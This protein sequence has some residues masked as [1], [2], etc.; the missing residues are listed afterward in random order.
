MSAQGLFAALRAASAG[1]PASAFLRFSFVSE[2]CMASAARTACF[3]PLPG[4]SDFLQ[5][6]GTG[7][8]V[9]RSRAASTAVSNYLS[10]ERA[11]N[12]ARLTALMRPATERC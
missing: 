6:Q 1:L 3:A 11:C 10:V 4:I 12:V 9:E 2:R 5:Q 8:T 7:V